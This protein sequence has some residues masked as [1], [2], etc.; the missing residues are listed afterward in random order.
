MLIKRNPFDDTGQVSIDYV[1]GVTIF[2]F[3]FFFLYSILDSLF[4]PLQGNSDEVQIMAERASSNL[5]ES[6]NMLAL[7]SSTPNIIDSTKASQFNSYL[8]DPQTYQDTLS[9]MG[10]KS[11]YL[12]YSLNVSLRFFNDTP[13]PNPINPLLI[14]GSIPDDNTK[15]GQIVRLVCLP[16][17]T[18]VDCERLKLVVKVWL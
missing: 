15:V 3:T 5:V 10:L 11:T 18:S 1:I 17:D 7:D 9:E 4:L 8:N 6:A 14:G 12:N 16:D 13:Y 2:I